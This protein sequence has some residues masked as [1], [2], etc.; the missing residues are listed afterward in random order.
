MTPTKLKLY[1]TSIIIQATCRFPSHFRQYFQWHIIRME[2]RPFIALRRTYLI[3]SNQYPAQL[4]VENASHASYLL[5]QGVLCI[6]HLYRSVWS[7][8]SLV[9]QPPRR[10][11]RATVQIGDKLNAYCMCVCA[12]AYKSVA[13]L[14]TACKRVHLINRTCIATYM[15]SVTFQE[16]FIGQ[17][18]TPWQDDLWSMEMAAKIG[19]ISPFLAQHSTALYR[20]TQELYFFTL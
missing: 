10:V 13:L 4:I 9:Q 16:K 6:Q 18:T 12:F 17:R 15:M 7:F 11:H 8:N 1:D 20:E 5:P 14:A 2:G 19:G 3:P